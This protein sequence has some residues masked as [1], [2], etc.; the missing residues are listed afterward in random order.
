MSEQY[1]TGIFDAVALAVMFPPNKVEH[2]YQKPRL[3]K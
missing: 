2:R 3:E 1:Q